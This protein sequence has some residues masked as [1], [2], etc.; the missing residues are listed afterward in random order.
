MKKRLDYTP[1]SFRFSP[2]DMR[3]IAEISQKTQITNRTDI[4]RHALRRL[5]DELVIGKGGTGN[6]EKRE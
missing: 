6:L 4:I 5:R 3:L 1:V 2:E